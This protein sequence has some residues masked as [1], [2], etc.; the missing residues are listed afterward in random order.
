M[1]NLARQTGRKL[2]IQR[3]FGRLKLESDV[4]AF[5]TTFA[6]MHTTAFV[7]HTLKISN[8]FATSGTAFQKISVADVALFFSLKVSS[9]DLIGSAHYK[10]TR[11]YLQS[12][13]Q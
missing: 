3:P 10:N 6:S 7:I 8:G 1:R 5:H 11:L 4:I 12:N 2:Q 13:N 9:R